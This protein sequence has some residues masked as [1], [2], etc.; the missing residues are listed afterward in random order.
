M[1]QS[2]RYKC[3]AGEDFLLDTKP[4]ILFLSILLD[5]AV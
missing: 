4:K 1:L 2:H 3:E 5:L